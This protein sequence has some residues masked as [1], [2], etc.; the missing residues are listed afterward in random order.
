MSADPVPPF[1]LA[2]RFVLLIPMTADHVGPLL[3]A[4]TET[5]RPSFMVGPMGPTDHGGIREPALEQR[6]GG[7]HYPFVTWGTELDR[8][9]GSTRFYDM[10]TWDWAGVF[11]G[12]EG[13]RGPV[14]LDVTNIGYTWVASFGPTHTVNTEANSRMLALAF[15][16][17]QVQSAVR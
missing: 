8:V 3:A 16:C 17:W 11:P 2:G 14:P 9:V 1:S 6:D 13:F 7:D 5:D 10:N 12:A 4:A 15:D